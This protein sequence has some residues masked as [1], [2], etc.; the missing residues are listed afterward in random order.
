MRTSVIVWVIYISKR[1][2]LS[3]A[4]TPKSHIL[5]SR[6]TIL[7]FSLC[8]VMSFHKLGEDGGDSLKNGADGTICSLRSA[9]VAE[10]L[11]VVEFLGSRSPTF[12]LSNK[13]S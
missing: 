11:S 3:F 5:K 12:E 6:V 1:A 9:S 2:S 13:I 8:L 7:S 10:L 4:Q